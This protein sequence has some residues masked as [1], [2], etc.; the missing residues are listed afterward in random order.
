MPRYGMISAAPET[1]MT[2]TSLPLDS[3]N[4]LVTLGN[5]VAIL[6]PSFMSST[7]R[8]GDPSGTATDS[9]Q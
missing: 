7:Q 2:L 1:S 6:L 4:L 5:D 8:T 9:L 3:K